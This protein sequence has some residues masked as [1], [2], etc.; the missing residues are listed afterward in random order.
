[1]KLRVEDA[2]GVRLTAEV[3]NDSWQVFLG[4][5]KPNSQLQSNLIKLPGSPEA[6]INPND[7]VIN[8]FQDII[9]LFGRD[10]AALSELELRATYDGTLGPEPQVAILFAGQGTQQVGMASD[11]AD[12]QVC[13]ELFDKASAILGYD[14][15]KL[16][17][18]GPDEQLQQ[19][20]YSQ[21]AVMVTSLAAITRWRLL[22]PK[23]ASKVKAM[24]GFS[25]GE[26]GALVYSGAISFEDGIRLVK[27][28]AEAMQACAEQNNGGMASV[29][30]MEYGPL[31]ALCQEASSSTGH[32]VKIA[33]YLFP[34]GRTVSGDV[35]AI[36][37]V[38]EHAV[39]KGAKK[40]TRI[41]TS[42][43][44]HTAAMAGAQAAL[45]TALDNM[46][47]QLPAVPVFSNVSGMPYSSVEEIRGLLKRQVVEAVAWE[48]AMG[49]LVQLQCTKIVE[50]GPGMQLK[51]M[52]KRTDKNAYDMCEALKTKA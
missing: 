16:C 43:A 26:F 29:A 4:A 27:L 41:K 30:G 21:P 20:A 31:N 36:E 5:L 48:K 44:F 38:C 25:L 22:N 50:T 7:P 14:L 37:Y 13:K 39:A 11:L 42:G 3:G 40:A 24:A 17:N 15:L 51:A 45:G 28:R 49:A 32:P 47:I 23:E 6:K 46:Q 1:M 35:E 33:N 19:T 52:L 12:I 9:S 34:S 18:E 8:S 2:N 10:A